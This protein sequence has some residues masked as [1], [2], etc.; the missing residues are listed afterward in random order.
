MPLMALLII[1]ILAMLA[2]SIDIG[3]IV[4][5][6]EELQN[7]A[8]AGALA[9]A[10]QLEQYYIQYYQPGASQATI[11]SSAQA[12]A[13]LF[14]RNY[15][16]FHRAGNTSSVVCDTANDVVLGYQDANTAFTTSVPSGTFPNTVQVTLRLDGGQNTNPQLALFFGPVLGMRTVTVTTVARATIYNGD[17]SSFSGADG[18]LLPA[19]MDQEIWQNFL[20]T[21]QGSMPE[22]S[23]TAPTS[24]ASGSVPSPAVPSA[25]QIQVVP[26]PNGSPGGWNYLSLNSSSN[27]NADLK[28]W[29]ANGLGASDLASLKAGAQLPLPTQ[30][31][32]PDNA[33]YFWKGIPG[34]RGGSEPF[35]APGSIRILPLY[36]HVPTDEAGAGNYIANAKDQ[37]PWTGSGGRG[38]NCWYNIVQFVGVV[39]TDNTNDGLSVQAAAVSDPNVVLTNVGAAGKPSSPDQ[40]RTFF[41]APKLTY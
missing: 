36:R 33:S 5:T 6:N 27:S 21:G 22:F 40:L 39:V 35:P 19:T 11:V 7:A 28:G 13:N 2:F 3:Y 25:A 38:Q 41:A 8:D 24:T 37:G 14:A 15:A 9:A 34:N 30:P 32:N 17:A 26:D 20:K 16:S 29:F 12:Q 31:P 10:E 4:Q 23:F 18:N 1:P